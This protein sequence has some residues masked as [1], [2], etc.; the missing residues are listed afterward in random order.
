MFL[1]ILYCL[2]NT[3]LLVQFKILSSAQKMG[4]NLP[5]LHS[6]R[7]E[8][9]RLIGKIIGSSSFSMDKVIFYL[10]Q[11]WFFEDIHTNS[12]EPIISIQ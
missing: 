2:K 3:I 12:E 9:G 10:K 4:W 8:S 1:Y 11:H 7:D 6:S 5:I